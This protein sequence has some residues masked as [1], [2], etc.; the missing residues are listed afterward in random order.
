MCPGFFINLVS[1]CSAPGSA[2]QKRILRRSNNGCAFG[3]QLSKKSECLSRNNS[4][5]RRSQLLVGRNASP[6]LVPCRCATK[7]KHVWPSINGPCLRHDSPQLQVSLFNLLMSTMG[8]HF[9]AFSSAWC[10]VTRPKRYSSL[11]TTGPLTILNQS[12]KIGYGPIEIRLSYIVCRHTRRNLIQWRA[13]G[14]RLESDQPMDASTKHRWIATPG[15]G[16]LSKIF[17]EGH[18]LSPHKCSV[19]NE[20]AS[21]CFCLVGAGIA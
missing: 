4:L 18:N 15:S 11:S 17:N 5:G 2:L 20:S 9:S 14:S 16:S 6:N 19:T 21:M 7:S 12:G 10:Y 8:E 3:S 13:Y 1:Q